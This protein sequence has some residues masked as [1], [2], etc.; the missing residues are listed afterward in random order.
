MSSELKR[1]FSAHAGDCP[2][3]VEYKQAAG[4]AM[5]RFGDRYRITPTD[6]L[7]DQLKELI[8]HESVELIYER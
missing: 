3:V 8:G 1:A 5:V 6:T 7:L 4:S 2:I